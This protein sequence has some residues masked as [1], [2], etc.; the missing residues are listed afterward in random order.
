MLLYGSVHLGLF[1]S[2]AASIDQIDRLILSVVVRTGFAWLAA[3]TLVAFPTA[4][5][6]FIAAFAVNSCIL[7][8]RDLSSRRSRG[9]F[10]DQQ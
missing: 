10:R 9:I 5:L 4:V 1:L 2:L 7:P 3:T 6:V 8:R